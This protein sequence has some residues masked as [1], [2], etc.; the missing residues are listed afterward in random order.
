VPLNTCSFLGHSDVS[1]PL[2]S[3]SSDF[4]VQIAFPKPGLRQTSPRLILFYFYF[5][6]HLSSSFPPTH[7]FSTPLLLSPSFVQL[8]RAAPPCQSFFR[9]CCC[10]NQ[11]GRHRSVLVQSCFPDTA[12]SRSLPQS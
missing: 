5:F 10:F 7:F 4:K 3:T 11:V 1:F 6:L 2:G 8:Y 12:F 9:C